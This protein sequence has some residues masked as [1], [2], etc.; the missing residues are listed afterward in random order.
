MPPSWEHWFGTTSRGQALFW[1]LTA[2]LRNT[3]MFGLL[4]ALISRA[5]SPSRS[6]LISGYRGGRTD[7]IIMAVNDTLGALP[8]IPILLLIYFVLRDQMTW[9]LLAV[10]AALLSWNHDSAG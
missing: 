9:P 7:Q 3:L 1:Q 10:V 2:A 8:N 4:V 6:G 5:S